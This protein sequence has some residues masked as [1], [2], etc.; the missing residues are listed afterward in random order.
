MSVSTPL[1]SPCHYFI[2][3]LQ[4]RAPIMGLGRAAA[5]RSCDA[6]QHTAAARVL[7]AAARLSACPS[8]NIRRRANSGFDIADLLPHADMHMR[9][10]PLRRSRCG[11]ERAHWHTARQRLQVCTGPPAKGARVSYVSALPCRCHR[12]CHGRW[13]PGQVARCRALGPLCHNVMYLRAGHMYMVLCISTMYTPWLVEH[14][15]ECCTGHAGGRGGCCRLWRA[16]AP[17]PSG[18]CRL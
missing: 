6:C 16:T 17:G 15:T 5:R 3:L 8:S 12:R 11:R 7:L 14:T 18:C 4:P 2:V 10:P 13:S 9:W 1:Q